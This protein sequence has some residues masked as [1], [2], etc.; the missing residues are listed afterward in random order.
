MNDAGA[1]MHIESAAAGGVV[2]DNIVGMPTSK[3]SN[4]S[5]ILQTNRALSLLSAHSSHKMSSCGQLLGHSTKVGFHTP[6]MLSMEAD[7]AES[8]STVTNLRDRITID[9]KR[10]R[11]DA[12]SWGPQPQ[13][14]LEKTNNCHPLGQGIILDLLQLSSHLQRIEQ[15]RQST[16]SDMG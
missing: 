6:Q 7:K 13:L 15:Q 8:T 10:H 5:G 3:T 12:I 2:T 16:E 1:T 9:L 14:V 11:S 4:L